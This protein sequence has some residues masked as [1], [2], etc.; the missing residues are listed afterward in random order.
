MDGDIQA[1]DEQASAL[2][3]LRN[4]VFIGWLQP[5]L[6]GAECRILRKCRGFRLSFDSKTRQITGL[7]PAAQERNGWNRMQ[8]TSEWMETSRHLTNKLARIALAAAHERGNV[9]SRNE[10]NAVAKVPEAARPVV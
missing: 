5:L 3:I 2:R 10:L 8:D 6:A 1:F 7:W 9:L 4:S